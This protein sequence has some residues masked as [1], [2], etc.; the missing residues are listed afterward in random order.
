MEQLVKALAPKP[1]LPVFLGRETRTTKDISFDE[2]LYFVNKA[3]SNEGF[4][5]DESKRLE[6]LLSCVSGEA[7]TRCLRLECQGVQVDDI[8]KEFVKNYSDNTPGSER[9]RSLHNLIQSAD[10]NINSFADKLE[11][12]R[13]WVDSSPVKVIYDPSATMKASFLRGIYNP[14]IRLGLVQ[15]SKDALLNFSDIKDLA[16][17]LE[18]EYNKGVSVGKIAS[19]ECDENKSVENMSSLVKTLCE[20]VENLQTHMGNMNG[21][22][23]KFNNRGRGQFN[24][25]GRGQF[26]NRGRGQF[27]NRGRGQFNNR[28]RG[29]FNNRGGGQFDSLNQSQR[30]NFNGNMRGGNPGFYNGYDERFIICYYCNQ[31]GHLQ[32]NCPEWKRQGNNTQSLN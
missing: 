11:K 27:N 16:V 13:Y 21:N 9:L 15:S 23:Y 22:G 1:K 7:R 19:V 26:N 8:I 32:R 29:Q 25:R 24:N 3:L 6:L 5:D 12:M 31:H 20:K 17:E 2:W 28:G 18:T 10:E 4:K 30:G 14:T